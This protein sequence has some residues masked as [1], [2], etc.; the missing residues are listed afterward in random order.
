MAVSKN[1]ILLAAA[2]FVSGG[3]YYYV[4]NPESADALLSVVTPA[5]DEQRQFVSACESRGN[6]G[7]ECACAWPLVEAR[8]SNATHLE[9]FIAS[10][11][12]DNGQVRQLMGSGLVSG[13][14]YGLEAGQASDAARTKCNVVF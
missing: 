8:M 7:S 4:N 6:S 11:E 14:Q 12:G 10:L 5:S 3:G 1:V 13:F 9:I 2:V